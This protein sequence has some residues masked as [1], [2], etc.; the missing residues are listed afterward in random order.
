M[1]D[2]TGHRTAAEQLQSVL[3]AYAVYDGASH[4]VIIV[5]WPGILLSPPVN[6]NIRMAVAGDKD[7]HLT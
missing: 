7:Y 2:A 6:R 5:D 3:T 4:D 1:P